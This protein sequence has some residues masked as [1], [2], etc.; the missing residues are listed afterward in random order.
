M[1]S[2]RNVTLDQERLECGRAI[3]AARLAAGYKTQSAAAE[4]A[5]MD[6]SQLCHLESGRMIAT[7][8]TLRRLVVAWRCD[9]RLLFPPIPPRRR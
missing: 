4:A 7:H 2:T 3:F 6:R 1:S 9:P 8:R 5:G